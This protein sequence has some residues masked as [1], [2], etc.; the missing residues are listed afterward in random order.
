MEENSNMTS[1]Q[2]DALLDGKIESFKALVSGREIKKKTTTVGTSS[3]VEINQGDSTGEK[4]NQERKKNCGAIKTT[5]KKNQKK[6][7]S[8]QP[9]KVDGKGNSKRPISNNVTPENINKNARKR[10][11]KSGEEYEN[12]MTFSE[13]T[14]CEKMAVVPERYPNEVLTEDIVMKLEDFI[15]EQIDA[16][17]PGQSGPAPF[18][19]HRH[20]VRGVWKISCKD[21]QTVQWLTEVVKQFEQCGTVFKVIPIEDLPRPPVYRGWFAGRIVSQAIIMNRLRIQNPE[22]DFSSWN[23]V[24]RTDWPKGQAVHFVMST[25]SANELEKKQLLLGFGVSKSPFELLTESSD[26]K[27]NDE[28]T[29]EPIIEKPSLMEIDDGQN[30]SQPV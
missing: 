29:N 15:L 26:D 4:Q 10:D 14:K 21:E 22:F 12:C 23:L 7:K 19:H 25:E 28:K 16:L 2:E 24:K 5:K 18:F 11:R 17:V 3:K 30:G 8:V 27:T 6:Q 1:S 9:Q 13:A 20:L